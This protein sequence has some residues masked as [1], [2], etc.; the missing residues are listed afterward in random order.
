LLRF[1]KFIVS[2]Q[3]AK[4]HP[5]QFDVFDAVNSS[6]PSTRIERMTQLAPIRSL[7]FCRDAAAK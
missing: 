2:G 5:R 3:P 7:L 4:P 1:I 6:A